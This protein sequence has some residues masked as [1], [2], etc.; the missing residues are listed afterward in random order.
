MGLR[1]KIIRHLYLVF[2]KVFPENS[3][4]GLYSCL[5]GQEFVKLLPLEKGI[6]THPNIL[7]WWVT[8]HGVIKKHN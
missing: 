4:S 6:A 3:Q 7:A 1:A 2:L 8:V 5:S